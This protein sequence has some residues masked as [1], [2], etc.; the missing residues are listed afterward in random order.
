[1]PDYRRI[2]DAQADLYEQLVSRE[3]HAGNIWRALGQIRSFDGLDVV[4]LGAGTGRLTCM[5]APVVRTIRALDISQHMLHAARAKLAQTGLQNW[6]V[7]LADNRRLPLAEGIADVSIAGW[8][9]GHLTS[10]H[11]ETWRHEIGAVLAQMA[12]VLR[13]GGMIILLETLGTGQTSPRPPHDGLTA[14]YNLLEKE[15]GFASTWIR[16][17]YRFQSLDEAEVLTRFFFGDEL[18]DRVIQEG[19]IL[20][21]ECTGI[22]WATNKVQQNVR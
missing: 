5:L 1:L 12:R 21:P 16:T 15:R 2:Y 20:L 13:P 7:T 8:S 11:P 4:E 3:D 22:W 9:L 18:A 19:L 17:D 14:Y 6:Q 10:W